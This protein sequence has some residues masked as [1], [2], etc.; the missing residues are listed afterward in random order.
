MVLES[1]IIYCWIIPG[2][3]G[4]RFPYIIF[5]VV[6]VTGNSSR[7]LVRVMNNSTSSHYFG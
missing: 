6:S 5:A 1:K 3:V 2:L 4:N 7:Q